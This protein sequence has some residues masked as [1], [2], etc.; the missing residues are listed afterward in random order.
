[1]SQNIFLAE[2]DLRFETPFKKTIQDFQ[3]AGETKNAA[4]HQATLKAQKWYR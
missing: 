2:P 3:N 1:M 4:F